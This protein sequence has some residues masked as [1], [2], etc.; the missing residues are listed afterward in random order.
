MAIL[1]SNFG[2]VFDEPIGMK[3][4][5]CLFLLLSALSAFSLKAQKPTLA[6]GVVI[7]TIKVGDK[8]SLSIYLPID[9]DES[10]KWP[11]L[12][13]FD[14]KGN[15]RE[16][17][18]KYL[19]AAENQG[20]II[21]GSNNIHDSISISN[22]IMIT[23]RLLSRVK[24]LVFL[25][26]ERIYATGFSGGGRFACLVPSFIKEFNGV[27]SLG[28]AI[29]NYE[30]LTS[31]N[32]F[33]FIGIVG[34]EDF[35]YPDMRKARSTLNRLKFPNQLWVFNGGLQWPD[36]WYVERA[37][38]TA[39]LLAMSKGRIP[40]QQALIDANYT[41][42]VQRVRTLLGDREYLGAYEEL[43]EII[44]VFQVHKPV[45]SL[46]NLRK[47]LKKNKDYRIQRRDENAAL[48]KESLIRDEYQFNLLED[49]NTLN[50][51]NLGWWNYQVAELKK[52]K[53][54]NTKAE[55]RMGV[56]LLSYLNA[57][58]ED[59]IDIEE[60]EVRVNDEVL[61]FLWMIKTITE[62]DNFDYYLKIIS[63]SAKYEDFGTSLFYL[64]E[65]LKR[66]FKD[67]EVL[68]QLEN[69]ALLRIT[70]EFNDLVKKYL[71]DPRYDI[72][73]E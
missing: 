10:K 40:K 36:P 37:L 66:G 59:N 41:E 62:P 65:L 56:R 8:E 49:I 50:Y 57:L 17:I 4:V 67:R 16:A 43:S 23:N 25:E 60:A 39:T 70:P 1:N 33:H 29:P 58:I 53:L 18:S 35:G 44:S 15:L 69:T 9:Y 19:N 51:N 24:K 30:L 54:K 42:E 55:Q 3:K 26:E 38:S 5:I 22:N 7:D 2:R 47:D 31:Q 11:L 68:Y 71:K 72:I 45:D 46:L 73:E 61:S 12:V 13:V 48:F 6:K 20:Y 21:T 63:D 28:A 64:E 52:Y 34:N 14:L 32:R 27:I